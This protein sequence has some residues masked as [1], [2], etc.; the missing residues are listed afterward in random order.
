MPELVQ[1]LLETIQTLC[2]LGRGN[3]ATSPQIYIAYEHRDDAQYEAFLAQA[4]SKGFSCKH[5]HQSIVDKAVER[6]YGWSTDVHE[7]ISILSMT[8]KARQKAARPATNSAG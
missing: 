7:G 8:L 3:R 1:P 4:V 5:I 6:A 2:R